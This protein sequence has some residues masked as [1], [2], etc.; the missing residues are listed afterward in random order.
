MTHRAKFAAIADDSV[1]FVKA[2]RA[3]NKEGDWP[4]PGKVTARHRPR[5]MSDGSERHTD[6]TAS[7]L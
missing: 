6:K 1:Q 2:D 4:V 7:Q 3:R 5:Q